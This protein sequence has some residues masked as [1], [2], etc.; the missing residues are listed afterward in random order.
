MLR[1]VVEEEDRE[2]LGKDLDEI[3]REGARQM[4][5]LALD[6]ERAEYIERFN[7]QR[8]EQGRALVVG[9]GFGKERKVQLGAGTVPV[10]APRVNDR[11]FDED[12]ERIR[13]TSEIL[14]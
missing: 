7:N 5:V 12:G 4:I 6:A 9:N 2:V 8:D 13:F 10:K 1:I 11:R 14:P 3:A